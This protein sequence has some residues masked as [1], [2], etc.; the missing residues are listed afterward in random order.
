M[1]Y[2]LSRDKTTVIADAA[3]VVNCYNHLTRINMYSFRMRHLISIGKV[4]SCEKRMWRVG[5][6]LLLLCQLVDTRLLSQVY[7]N[8]LFSS[9]Q[10][11]TVASSLQFLAHKF[12]LDA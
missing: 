8:S 11:V 4:S 6:R 3:E 1:K 2:I 5:G 7:N 12:A 10:P 9:M